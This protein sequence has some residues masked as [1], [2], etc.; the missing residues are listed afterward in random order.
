MNVSA[1]IVNFHDCSATSD[2]LSKMITEFTINPPAGP[3]NPLIIREGHSQTVTCNHDSIPLIA[4]TWYREASVIREGVSEGADGCSCRFAPLDE[5]P[6]TR[7]LTFTDFA[8][9]S[10]GE[11]SCRVPV[12]FMVGVFNICQFDVVMGKVISYI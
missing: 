8:P 11:Y 9:A 5:T 2:D 10:A 12:P 4:T 1:G 6:G 3:D 7:E